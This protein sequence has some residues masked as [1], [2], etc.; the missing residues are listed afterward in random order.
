MTAGTAVLFLHAMSEVRRSSERYCPM[1]TVEIGGCWRDTAHRHGP[2]PSYR[3][4]DS[5]F[6]PGVRGADRDIPTSEAIGSHSFCGHACRML[7]GN[8]ASS[9]P[10]SAGFLLYRRVRS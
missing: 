8:P 1:I 10:P 3:T 7:A 9:S 2:D 6:C 4:M 5:G